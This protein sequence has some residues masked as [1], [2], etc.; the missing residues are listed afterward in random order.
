MTHLGTTLHPFSLLQRQLNEARDGL[1]CISRELSSSLA[2]YHTALSSAHNRSLL[3]VIS[4][5]WAVCCA[6]FW[7]AVESLSFRRLF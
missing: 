4:G 2:T 3:D 1:R 7:D 6:R 5:D